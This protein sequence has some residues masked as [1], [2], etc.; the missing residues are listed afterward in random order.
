[1]SDDVEQTLLQIIQQHK[2]IS[3]ENAQEYLN[4]LKESGRYEKDVY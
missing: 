4:E 1:M 2:N 3:A